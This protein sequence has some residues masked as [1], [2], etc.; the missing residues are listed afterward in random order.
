MAPGY[1]IAIIDEGN[2]NWKTIAEQIWDSSTDKKLPTDR[3]SAVFI[4]TEDVSEFRNALCLQWKTY[5]ILTDSKAPNI[6]D[7]TLWCK[8]IFSLSSNLEEKSLDISDLSLESKLRETQAAG[9]LLV[10]TVTS[11]DNALDLLSCLSSLIAQVA[12]LAPGSQKV[13][14]YASRWINT[15]TLSVGN[16][17]S[18]L[19]PCKFPLLYQANPSIDHGHSFGHLHI[20]RVIEIYVPNLPLLAYPNHCSR[21]VRPFANEYSSYSGKLR[22]ID[23][24]P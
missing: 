7:C 17:R 20:F 9:A 22:E 6:P 11:L 15:H 21:N 23:I 19:L 13:V 2:K 5:R 16:I 8:N 14:E 4:R 24:T 12:L 10:V 18:F 1:N 3:L